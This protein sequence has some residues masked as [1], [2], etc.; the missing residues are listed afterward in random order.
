VTQFSSEDPVAHFGHTLYDGAQHPQYKREGHEQ[1]TGQGDHDKSGYRLRTF[2]TPVE[3]EGCHGGSHCGRHVDDGRLFL[4]DRL[5]SPDRSVEAEIAND[6]EHREPE[7]PRRYVE[8][9]TRR[10]E[11][12]AR[13]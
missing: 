8:H 5:Q 2:P 3:P 13:F 9:P 11:R 10:A 12:L 4:W 1:I 6:V 7:A